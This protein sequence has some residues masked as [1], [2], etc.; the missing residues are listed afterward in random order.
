MW[1]SDTFSGT[2][3]VATRV[4]VHRYVSQHVGLGHPVLRQANESGIALDVAIDVVRW[5]RQS[6]GE[7]SVDEF[8]RGG[9]IL[10]SKNILLGMA[11]LWVQKSPKVPAV[12]PKESTKQVQGGQTL[13]DP[14]VNLAGSTGLDTALAGGR[15]GSGQRADGQRGVV[16]EEQPAVFPGCPRDWRDRGGFLQAGEGVPSDQ[17]FATRFCRRRLV[18]VGD[19]SLGGDK[20][21]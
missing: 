19:A 13:T 11:V 4:E 3:P 17:E 15:D 8:R 9:V 6:C 21:E 5:A 20:T 1:T 10:I 2:L 16:D 12:V 7:Q 14:W 18:L